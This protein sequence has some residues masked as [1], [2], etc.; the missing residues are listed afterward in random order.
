MRTGA[1]V[2]TS[3]IDQNPCL[4][5][6]LQRIQQSF[7]GVFVAALTRREVAGTVQAAR[8]AAAR[9]DPPSASSTSA[10]ATSRRCGLGAYLALCHTRLQAHAFSRHQH[11]VTQWI[12]CR[13]SAPWCWHQHANPPELSNSP[14]CAQVASGDNTEA[15]RAAVGSL[16][17]APPSPASSVSSAGPTLG[18]SA[19][20]SRP[21]PAPSRLAPSLAQGASTA[22]RVFPAH[23][24]S[25]VR[26]ALLALLASASESASSPC[27]SYRLILALSLRAG[28]GML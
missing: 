21:Q 27:M 1:I 8:P 25:G 13:V 16:S 4:M 17:L 22:V 9:P 26:Q 18:G 7:L 5:V 11:F 20:R 14:T 12:S 10:S 15:L 2:S 6:V 23:L 28:C 19:M 3:G 24:P